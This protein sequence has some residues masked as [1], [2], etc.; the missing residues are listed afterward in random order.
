MKA[1]YTE[2]DR[3]EIKFTA[4]SVWHPGIVAHVGDGSISVRI[5]DDVHLVSHARTWP[6]LQATKKAAPRV[7]HMPAPPVAAL[8]DGND[9][10]PIYGGGGH[11]AP[12]LLVP[13]PM[14]EFKPQPKPLPPGRSLEY[15]AFVRTQPCMVAAHVGKLTSDVGC[16]GGLHAHH[17]AP[18][19]HKSMG[20]KCSD[21]Y[22]VPLCDRH[23]L[24]WWH[25]KGYLPP[26]THDGTM[27][28]FAMEQRR[29]LTVWIRRLDD[30]EQTAMM[31]AW[32]ESRATKSEP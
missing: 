7:V 2:G 23:H 32:L 24:Q 4:R 16:E 28:M 31:V 20:A 19:G 26:F 29:L 6:K 5:G 14:R 10:G 27:E 13:V 1:T 30:A 12:G 18:K 8:D 9:D 11:F 15:L 21:F 3:V 17:A 25:Q 22:A